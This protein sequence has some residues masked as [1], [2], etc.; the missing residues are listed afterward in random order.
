MAK[1]NIIS[2]AVVG[3]ILLLLTALLV[4]VQRDRGSMG[5][6][7]MVYIWAVVMGIVG[8]VAGGFIGGSFEKFEHRGIPKKVEDEED[9]EDEDEEDEDEV[10]ACC[11]C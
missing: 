9:E 5:D 2:A 8:F 10:P 6:T 3:G 4:T 7:N 11:G 1:F